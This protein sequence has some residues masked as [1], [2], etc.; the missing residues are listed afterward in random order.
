MAE[1]AEV[2]LGQPSW[3]DD[4]GLAIILSPT[5][6]FDFTFEPTNLST[7]LSDESQWDKFFSHMEIW[8]F[9]QSR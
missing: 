3:S 7:L 1:K 9:G 6:L 8:C 4:A 2:Q 5:Q